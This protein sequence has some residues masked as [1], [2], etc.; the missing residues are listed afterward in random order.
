MKYA[1]VTCINPSCRLVLEVW[2]RFEIYEVEC[3]ACFQHNALV[4]T[5]RIT[6]ICGTCAS[7]YDDNHT[8]QGDRAVCVVVKGGRI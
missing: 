8:W 2:C 3:P 7:P 1:A 5:Y 6:G 4:D